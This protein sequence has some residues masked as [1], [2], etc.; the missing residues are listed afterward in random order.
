MPGTLQG[1]S[2]CVS[3]VRAG[4]TQG[5]V[6]YLLGYVALQMMKL[7]LGRAVLVGVC[8]DAGQ[9]SA[10]AQSPSADAFA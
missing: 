4:H 1:A 6:S 2:I 7:I 5:H 9:L 3:E 10:A 8:A